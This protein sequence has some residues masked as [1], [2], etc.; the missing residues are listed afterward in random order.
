MS[1]QQFH[2]RFMQGLTFDEEKSGRFTIYNNATRPELGHITEYRR[3]GYYSVG[4]GDYTIPDDFQIAFGHP[5]TILR[6]GNVYS[7]QTKYK[8]TGG[9]AA[10]FTPASFLVVESCPEGMQAWKQG[11]HF[12]GTEVTVFPEFLERILRPVYGDACINLD[13]IPHNIT[14]R[15]LPAELVRVLHQIENLVTGRIFN[16]MLL[17]SKVLECISIISAQ[18][19]KK[20][21]DV[22]ENQH[23]RER[24]KIGRDRVITLSI[25]DLELIR[26]AHEIID[27]HACMQITIPQLSSQLHIHEQKL[28]AGFHH[29]YHMTIWE[30][31]NSVRMAEAANLLATTDLS[32]QEI[33]AKVGYASIGSFSNMFRKNFLKSPNQFRRDNAYKNE[34]RR[35]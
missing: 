18:Y 27:E 16:E 12:H 2:Q 30:Y 24:V 31:A 15:Y 25:Q 5:E 8:M 3:D 26:K 1:M 22:I 9:E 20:Q 29:L 32:V 6:F 35:S 10:S 7:G 33:A 21:H 11:Q 34:V 28:K 4:I 13:R 14:Q 17:D 23:N 19:D